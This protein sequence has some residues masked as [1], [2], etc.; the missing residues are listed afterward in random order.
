VPREPLPPTAYDGDRATSDTLRRVAA[1]AIAGST[2]A[3][4]C[5]L[6]LRGALGAVRVESFGG[7]LDW[8]LPIVLSRLAWPIAAGLLW[9]AAPALTSRLRNSDLVPAVEAKPAAAA[10]LV[11]V[12]MVAGPVIWLLASSV[13]RALAITINGSWATGGLIFVA[14][15]FYS[16]IVVTYVPWMLAGMALV[17]AAGHLHLK[18]R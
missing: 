10:R 5:E 9:V 11:G 6:L 8:V 16:D 7:S 17:T 2:L 13:V 3:L 15:Q 14:P 1:A 18:G 4:G 12:A